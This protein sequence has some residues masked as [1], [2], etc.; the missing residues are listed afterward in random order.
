MVSIKKSLKEYIF[1][2]NIIKNI[3]VPQ[4]YANSIEYIIN[5]NI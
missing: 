5:S 4:E 2:S 3:N 1:D